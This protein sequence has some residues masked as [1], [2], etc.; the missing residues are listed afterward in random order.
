MVMSKKME[1]AVNKQVNA[2]MYSAYLYLSMVSY[3]QSV[4]LNGF[5]AWLKAQAQEEVL[6]AMKFF[7]HVIDLF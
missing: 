3:F 5:A 4:N 6:H 7:S 1:D 2:E